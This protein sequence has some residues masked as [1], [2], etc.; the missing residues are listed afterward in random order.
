MK[1]DVRAVTDFPPAAASAGTLPDV[2]LQQAARHGMLDWVGMDNMALP[3]QLETAEGA[4]Q[5]VAATVDVAV[6]LV[7]AQARGIHMSRLY[8]LLQQR[9][10]RTPLAPQ[11]L[12][13]L[14]DALVQ[15]QNGL[16]TRAR[17]QLRWDHLLLRPALVSAHSGWKAYPLRI[18]VK[19]RDDNGVVQIILQVDIDYS[20]TCP[21]SAALSRQAN[22]ARFAADFPGQTADRQAVHD[23]LASERGMAATPHAQRSRASVQVWLQDAVRQWPLEALID[24]MEAALA[25][26]VQ[27]AVK[28]EDEQAFAE[29]NAANLLFC[30]DAARRMADVLR[31][32]PGIDRF[33]VTAA[34]LESLHAHD[35]VARIGG[36][37]G[38]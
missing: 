38:I 32:F 35:A 2:A 14:L 3:L 31:R 27:T 5:T 4:M 13:E 30:E 18:E 23:W 28:R 15:S 12:A 29:R 24:A 17:L 1:D 26:P 9:L 34:H 6:N 16:S 25:T 22:A 19:H 21:A 11:L 8:L 20:S 7:D 37:A 33:E 36:R 10:A